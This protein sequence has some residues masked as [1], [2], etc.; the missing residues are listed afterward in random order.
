ML[1]AEDTRPRHPDVDTKKGLI[2]KFGDKIAN[3]NVRGKNVQFTQP[4]VEEGAQKAMARKRGKG[5][6]L[7]QRG[8]GVQFDRNIFINVPDTTGS[9]EEERGNGE[10]GSELDL[11][12]F[13][14]QTKKEFSTFLERY[15][16]NVH[17]QY[18]RVGGQD[19]L[20]AQPHAKEL[21]K[22]LGSTKE[23]M[24]RAEL[25]RKINTMLNHPEGWQLTAELL[26][27][28][29]ELQLFAAGFAHVSSPQGDRETLGEAM[30]GR[31]DRLYVKDEGTMHKGIRN[32]Q[33]FV[34]K[35]LVKIAG[36]GGILAGA[37]VGA[38]AG[39]PLGAAIGGLSVATAEGI[40][41][42]VQS[43]RKPGLVLERK[44]FAEVLES[45]KGNPDLAKYMK[46]TV[47]MDVNDFNVVDGRVVHAKPQ[48]EQRSTQPIDQYLRAIVKNVDTRTR[49]L[50][51][52]GVA[53]ADRDAAFGQHLLPGQNGIFERTN[54]RVKKDILERLWEK[55]RRRDEEVSQR[56]PE[57]PLND[58]EAKKALLVDKNGREPGDPFRGR[59]YKETPPLL[60]FDPNRIIPT[61]D[62]WGQREGSTWHGRVNE[63]N[64]TFLGSE[65]AKL[66]QSERKPKK[67]QP[68]VKFKPKYET[69][70]R[71]NPTTGEREIQT[72]AGE[73]LFVYDITI[74][75]EQRI[76]IKDL[77]KQLVYI[78]DRGNRHE[79]QTTVNPLTG[80]PEYT[81]A[82]F[83][84]T[85]NLS[86]ET[87][88]NYG[89]TRDKIFFI[90]PNDAPIPFSMLD[91]EITVDPKGGPTGGSI[92]KDQGFHIRPDNRKLDV[93]ANMLTDGRNVRPLSSVGPNPGDIEDFRRDVQGNAP[94][95]L[96]DAPFYGRVR[97][98]FNP[99]NLAGI[100]QDGVEITFDASQKTMGDILRMIEGGRLPLKDGLT[101][102][103]VRNYLHD[104]PLDEKFVALKNK[105]GQVI[106]KPLSKELLLASVFP[107]KIG[108]RLEQEKSLFNA[109]DA[110]ARSPL[111]M[112]FGIDD[113]DILAELDT[114]FD[115]TT[116]RPLP[117]N[118]ANFIDGPPE[119]PDRWGKDRWGQGPDSPFFCR[120]NAAA[121]YVP[122]RGTVNLLEEIN[123]D[124]IVRDAWDQPRF[125]ADGVTPDPFFLREN[126]SLT[127]PTRDDRVLLREARQEVMA[128]LTEA[129]I[130]KMREFP[131]R[132]I[133]TIDA[134]LKARK[135]GGTNFA[136][137]KRNAERDRPLLEERATILQ[138]REAILERW[139][140]A[141]DARRE[142]AQ[143][144]PQYL[145]DTFGASVS[146]A[147]AALDEIRNA[148]TQTGTSITLTIEGR[149]RTISSIPDRRRAAAATMATQQEQAR[150]SNPRLTDESIEAYERRLGGLLRNAEETYNDAW[151][152]I[153]ADA[154][155]LSQVQT[156]IEQL[157][158]TIRDANRDLEPNSPL[159]RERE[160]VIYPRQDDLTRMNDL[161]TALVGSPITNLNS[162]SPRD[163]LA[164]I[165]GMASPPGWPETENN[166][167]INKEFLVQTLLMARARQANPSSV[168]DLIDPTGSVQRILTAPGATPPVTL[169]DILVRSSADIAADTGL[170]EVEVD[171][172]QDA[173]NVF[174]QEM[175]QATRAM[176][177]DTMRAIA[178]VEQQVEAIGEDPG[179]RAE[180][181]QLEVTSDVMKRQDKVFGA[182]GMF[183]AAVGE[184]LPVVTE[185]RGTPPITVDR[186]SVFADLNDTERA[187][188]SD[189]EQTMA[190]ERQRVIDEARAEYDRASALPGANISR[191]QD[192][193]RDR[194]EN[195]PEAFPVALFEIYDTIFDYKDRADRGAYF[196][197]I[198][199]ILPPDQL[200][201]IMQRNAEETEPP[202]NGITDRND[203]IVN[204]NQ[205][206]REL[207]VNRRSLR[208]MFVGVIDHLEGS[209]MALYDSSAISQSEVALAA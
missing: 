128:D 123:L 150:N 139:Q 190:T 27:Q 84:A 166:D 63:L 107:E 59:N 8:A 125:L 186:A 141:Q 11:V 9:L 61:L 74:T 105:L 3:P 40:Y 97:T 138:N 140:T 209:G 2:G 81:S 119:P 143:Q 137:R 56:T 153:D 13:Q 50:D 195:A 114:F 149:R 148:R 158:T 160:A 64:I 142:A 152:T 73:A 168:D 115:P 100:L 53:P 159:A 93:K 31:M 69:P 208:K 49:Y 162:A 36:G 77:G 172:A 202:L 48:S 98:E 180:I 28:Q 15:V 130:V 60:D 94:F 178:R 46:A 75:K 169:H 164:E 25:R 18:K 5:K 135:E 29:T 24:N 118:R 120:A 116:G 203:F 20:N 89:A 71:T 96:L 201:D 174:A 181:A 175:T 80:Q 33:D 102:D 21:M 199:S 110:S 104:E 156:E 41:K 47:G 65:Q 32:T 113:P 136:E 144:L 55:Q 127:E 126:R 151:A 146:T 197:K 76:P 79:V 90:P 12:Q 88:P 26:E 19:M 67:D 37:G 78:D 22:L 30:Q 198:I 205:R 191:L 145:T 133:S 147:E 132:K 1:T 70:L 165:N 72:D 91:R 161:A 17:E 200:I 16:A 192:E 35:H 112:R 54:E 163:V 39:G 155:A 129:L 14:P 62:R 167:P 108:E 109:Q 170:S 45:I 44:A 173:M 4:Y 122:G 106:G 7:P 86:D 95:D 204:L 66:N 103:D 124:H 83:T 111:D 68:V 177:T 34:T 207:Q 92:Y 206:V 183:M 51:D 188:Y 121:F 117:P 57:N 42:A 52:L 85:E 38:A 134:K 187:S 10:K 182:T 99:D 157:Q 6:G 184:R 171:F 194:V 196:K 87:H 131:P 43:G 189:I 193:Y 185:T 101:I 82:G 179:L 154:R 176:S 58:E 23:N